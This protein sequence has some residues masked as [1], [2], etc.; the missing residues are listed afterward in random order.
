[1]EFANLMVGST[2]YVTPLTTEFGCVVGGGKRRY[3]DRPLVG[4]LGGSWG[5]EEPIELWQT[6]KIEGQA[7]VKTIS[8][9]DYIKHERRRCRKACLIKRLEEMNASGKSKA[10]HQCGGIWTKRLVV[11]TVLTEKL[12]LT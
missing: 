11:P 12:P 4:D 8:E 9:D 1:M 5:G 2:A 7:R 6:K 10:E 3:V